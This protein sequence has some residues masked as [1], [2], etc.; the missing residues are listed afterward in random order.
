M[1]Y[2]ALTRG[3]RPVERAAGGQRPLLRAGL[4]DA[5]GGGA[6]PRRLD[7]GR[8]GGV[9][10]ERVGEGP[11]AHLSDCEGAGCGTSVNFSTDAQRRPSNM[12]IG[13]LRAS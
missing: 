1:A 13:I 5:A 7:H 8:V 4:D 11:G 12:E 3:Q 6:G 2:S 10:A 9:H